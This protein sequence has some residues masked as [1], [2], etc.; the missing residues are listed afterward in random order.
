MLD[1]LHF[2]AAAAAWTRRNGLCAERVG[3]TLA[4]NGRY[5][6]TTN[7]DLL[8]VSLE[9][10]VPQNF[11]SFWSEALAYAHEA[12]EHG[13]SAQVYVHCSKHGVVHACGDIENGCCSQCSYEHHAEL[14]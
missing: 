13:L 9:G 14:L 8:G 5:A 6:L 7:F 10:F 3:L 12:N 11:F 2:A 4:H 1:T